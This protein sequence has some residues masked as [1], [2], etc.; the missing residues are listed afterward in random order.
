MEGTDFQDG[1]GG[2]MSDLFEQMISPISFPNRD[3][4]TWM[5]FE[6]YGFRARRS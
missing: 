3:A 2:Y 6:F 5:R 1:F 4:L